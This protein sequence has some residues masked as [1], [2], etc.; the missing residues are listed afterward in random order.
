MARV[1][2]FEIPAKD[3]KKSAAF[4]K[5][6]F[7]WKI[8]QWG[9]EQYWMVQTGNSK[10]PGIDGDEV[11]KLVKTMEPAPKLIFVTA[12]DDGGKTRAR[13]LKLGAYAYFDK[14]IASLK[15]LEDTIIKAVNG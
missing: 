4:Y 9:K 10:M 11:L 1:V 6:V 8:K 12:Y 5:K 3:P 14:P 7:G 2:H 15:I 13:L